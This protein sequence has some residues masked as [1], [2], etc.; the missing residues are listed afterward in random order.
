HLREN[1]A[2]VVDSSPKLLLNPGSP[3]KG[4][5]IVATV[6]P[7]V[8]MRVIPDMIP[9]YMLDIE[10]QKDSYMT[11]W[12]NW[13]RVSRSDDGRFFF[14]VSDH[15]GYG[16]HINIYEYV[17]A[18]NDL[19]HKV[20]DFGETVGWTPSSI[21]DGKMHG[22]PGIMP[23]GTM[24]A[25]SHYGVYPDSSWWANGY[26]GSWLIS[27][28]IYT[29]KTENWG[30]PCVGSWLPFFNLDRERG[31]FAA[32]SGSTMFF[33]WDT[34]NKRTRYAGYPPNG[35]IWWNR[36]MLLDETTGKFWSFDS[37]DKQRRF[38]SFDPEYN[39][40]VRYEVPSPGMRGYTDRRAMDGWYYCSD[41]AKGLYRFNPNGFDGPV[42][43]PLGITWEGT[44]DVRQMVVS[45][46]GR[47][48]Y[49]L[50]HWIPKS[51]GSPLV[52]YDVMTGKKK[53]IC[54]LAEYYFAE[55]GYWPFGSF[56][57]EISE[58]GSSIVI[59]MN[60]TFQGRDTMYGKPA[61]F[62]VGIPEEE[63]VED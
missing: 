43:E 35:W 22:Y 34:I 24:W 5:F 2:F 23:D 18:R 3:L 50:P 60:G 54:W 53:A 40:F 62:V 15:R 17:P 47:Y 28:N 4:E 39:T 19:V 33:C 36:G 21:T 51:G 7:T 32:T 63:R 41:G 20:I 11:A 57:M 8:K 13:G 16:A 42:S 6:P 52:Q 61:L 46:K 31:R 9:E 44:H 58:D 25:A 48:V 12:A 14:S 1:N 56:G 30:I 38:M 59:V 37:A 49:Y 45:P 55:Y 29:H 27:Y 26:R 10:S